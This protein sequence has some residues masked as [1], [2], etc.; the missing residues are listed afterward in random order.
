MEKGLKF[1]QQLIKHNSGLLKSLTPECLAQIV[2][3]NNPKSRL[4]I[5]EKTEAGQSLLEQISWFNPQ[6]IDFFNADKNERSA[7][8]QQSHSD[9]IQGTGNNIFRPF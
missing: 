8:P 5:L 6:P 7:R 4:A 3:V 2:S 1:L 9:D